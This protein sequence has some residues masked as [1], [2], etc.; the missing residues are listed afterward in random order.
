MIM[1][2]N[3]IEFGDFQTPR[4]LADAI[5]G[6]LHD[7]CISPSIIVE[8][9]CGLGSFALAAL[10][11]F[12][13][14]SQLFA[15]DINI[16]YISALRKILG[17]MNGIRCQ[18]DQQDAF[19]FDW[20]AFFQSFREEILVL[21][22]PPWVTNASLGAM[23]SDNLPQK[24]NF[25]NHSGF[26]AKTGKANFDI[27]EWIL[28]KIL[29]S[30][31]SQR[32]CMA[33]LCKTAVARKVL[34]HSWVN[35]FNINRATIHLIDAS[36]HFGVTVDAC[37]LIVHTGAP[38][39]SLTADTYSDLSFDHKLITFGLVGRNLV[40]NV[41]EYNRLRDLDGH[42]YYKWRSGLKH[43]AASVMEFK[44]E[45][46]VLIN[47]MGEPVEIEQTYLYPLLKSSDLANGRLIP[48]RYVLVTQRK[49]GDDTEDIAQTAPKTWS[50]LLRHAEAL[51]RR[52]SIIYKKRARF[53]V[54]GVGTYTFSPWKVAVSGLYKSLRFEV[55][56]EY[57][58]QPVVFDD[59]CYFIPCGTEQEASFINLLLNSELTKS[60]LHALVFF[61][62]KRPLN[63]DI[64]N[65]IDL[66]KIAAQLGMENDAREYLCNA[67]MFENHQGL[68]VFEKQKTYQTKISSR[69]GSPRH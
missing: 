62:A 44:R 65:R 1:I 17:G 10:N 30:L 15:F 28:I 31:G 38:A 41:D 13:T 42:S 58:N 11:G 60:F 43:D 37:L 61:D 69:R 8:P 4:S 50:Y 19:T 52:Q 56:G 34:R 26:A 29:E 68:L 59:T 14:A 48:Q 2:K 66:K 24:T 20:K 25:Q 32:G 45:D 22:N 55:I 35:R 47:G 49:P 6:L 12:H 9:T 46:S 33:M 23:G 7:T 63:I 21:G 54:F 64:L 3:K 57:Q 67:A 5:V 39:A 27:S 18:V 40:A 51:D 53:S 16:N 36:V